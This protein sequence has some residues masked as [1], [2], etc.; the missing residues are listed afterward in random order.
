MSAQ[1]TYTDN[2]YLGQ[3]TTLSGITTCAIAGTNIS[4]DP[5]NVFWPLGHE[6]LIL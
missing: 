5:W 3:V 1:T 6:I 2:H 4:H